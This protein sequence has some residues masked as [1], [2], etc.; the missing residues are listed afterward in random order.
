MPIKILKNVAG[1][2]LAF[3]IATVSPVIA[4]HKSG[5]PPLDFAMKGTNA[6]GWT[7]KG[8]C[9][10]DMPGNTCVLIMRNCNGS[11]YDIYTTTRILKMLEREVKNG[12]SIVV[13]TMTDSG[14][15]KDR[16]C[17]LT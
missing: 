10:N 5:V 13:H 8:D 11:G 4:G 3:S 14:H 1:L 17:S 9:A 2:M 6:P 12:R 15:F 16:I 7:S